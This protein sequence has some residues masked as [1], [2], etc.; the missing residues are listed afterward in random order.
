MKIWNVF[1][2]RQQVWRSFVL[3]FPEEIPFK[4]MKFKK[5][6]VVNLT[7]YEPS[8]H[9]RCIAMHLFSK[10][11]YLLNAQTSQATL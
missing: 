3:R 11:Y 1:I 7:V 6:L 2:R 9:L 5:S 8:K 4:I 10:P